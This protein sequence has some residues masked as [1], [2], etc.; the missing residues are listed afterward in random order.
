ML[1]SFGLAALEARTVGIPV[2]ARRRTG[3]ADFVVDGRDGWL[4]DSDA[5]MV[6]ALVRL[7]EQPRR[8][9][10]PQ[11]ADRLDQ[12]TWPAVVRCTD[13]L[14]ARAI[15]MHAAPRPGASNPAVAG[16]RPRLTVS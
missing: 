3:I 9:R 10:Q 13:A 11:P 8:R 14:Y 5:E 15:A 6:D 1:E 7:A 16:D 2:V 4:C 12:M